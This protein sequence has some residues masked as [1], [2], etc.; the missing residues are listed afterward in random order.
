M[1]WIVKDVVKD[2]SGAIVIIF[3]IQFCSVGVLGYKTNDVLLNKRFHGVHVFTA[4]KNSL[5]AQA[6]DQN[7]KQS[8]QNC[9]KFE[10]FVFI[11]GKKKV[12]EQW[13]N[14]QCTKR[15]G[16]KK[17]CQQGNNKRKGA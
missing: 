4:M 12:N 17:R 16:E 9:I 13:R 8:G 1:T 6:H 14:E 3:Q 5:Y 7:K 11:P 10:L 2:I 15:P